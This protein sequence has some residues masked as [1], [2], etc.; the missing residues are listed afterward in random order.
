MEGRSIS[1]PEDELT[2]LIKRLVILNSK[3]KSQVE[4]LNKQASKGKDE[5]EVES[6]QNNRN[7]ARNLFKSMKKDEDTPPAYLKSLSVNYE[8][9][10]RWMS[11]DPL[12]SEKE[13]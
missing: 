11:A 7:V 8:G 13:A 3:L 1:T 4:A 2:D 9:K 6:L 12:A 10:G 5:S